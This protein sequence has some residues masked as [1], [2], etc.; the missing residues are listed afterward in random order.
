MKTKLYAKKTLSVFLAVMMLM[1]AWVFV[2]P[3]KAE[4][5]SAATVS[6]NN[7][8]KIAELNG[9][10]FEPTFTT[11]SGNFQGDNASTMANRGYYKNVLYSPH[12]P[13][14]NNNLTNNDAGVYFGNL[15]NTAD[16]ARVWYPETTLIWDG[17]TTPQIP[18]LFDIDSNESNRVGVKNVY[19]SSDANGLVFKDS[20]WT[21]KSECGKD[22]NY[23]T[24]FT[25]DWIMQN[26][27]G[28]YWISTSSGND[29]ESMCSSKGYWD[30]YGTYLQYTG[31]SFGS[32]STYYKAITPTWV[33]RT[34]SNYTG[35]TNKTIY[36]IDYEPLKN[37]L[38]SVQ[39][40]IDS[41]NKEP[42]K[43]TTTS[44]SAFVE[45]AKKLVAANPNNYITSSKNDVYGW[46]SAVSSAL[47]DYNSAKNLAVQ[48]YNVKF[49]KND[50]TDV[51]NR[52]Y[53]YGASIN[54]SSI[55]ADYSNTIK[56]IGETQHQ[57]YKWD[58]AR[59]VSTVTDDIIINEVE[60]KTEA[61]KFGAYTQGETQHSRTCSVCS[62]VQTQNHTKNAGY[63]TKEETCTEDGV[64]T[65]DCATCGKKAIETS[66]INNI[67]G[68]NFSGAAIENV[69]GENGN[70]WKKCSR[71][72]AYGWLSTEDAYENHNWD[73]NGDGQVNASDAVTVAST[74]HSQGSETYTC[75]VCNATW[76]KTL[77]YA[78]HTIT[79]TAKKDVTNQCGGDGNEAFWSCSVCSRVWKD[80]ALT[81]ELTDTTDADSDG[82]PDALE[83]KGPDHEF[84]GPYASVTSGKDGTHHRQCARF[85]QCGTYGP[86][87]KHTWGDPAV[88]DATCEKAGKKVYTCTSGC[89]QTY[90][91]TIDKVAHSMTKHDAV[92]AKCGVAGSIEYYTC[93]IC[94]KNYS[95][96]NGTTV[97]TSTVVPALEHK[98]T[99]H[100]EYDTLKTSATCQAAAVY[101]NHCDYCKTQI[102]GAEH[103]YGE[104]DTV[105][106]HNFNGAIVKNA[107]G[108]HSYKC[109]VAGCTEEGKK[110]TC[111]FT[112]E[113]TDVPSTCHTVGY[114]ITKC[115]T[116]GNEKKENK[117]TF[118]FNNHDGKKEVRFATEAKCN[119]N[120][121][122]G[123]TYCLGCK[124]KIATGS[125]IIADKAVHPHEDMQTYDAKAS[126]CQTAGWKEYKYC[127]ACD[128]YE[129]AKV[130]VPVRDHKFTTYTSNGDGTH[131]AVC[132]TCDPN[133][134]TPATDKQ[135]CKGGTANCQSGAI[136]TVCDTAYGEE[137]E[138][139]HVNTVFVPE[140]PA[141]CQK[142]GTEAYYKC[143]DCGV[144]IGTVEKLE[145][146]PHVYSAWISNGDGTH[147]KTCSLC[148]PAVADRATET[149][150]CSGGTAYCN[151]LAKCADC[152]SEYGVLNPENHSTT[153]NHL[154]D[155]VK[156]TCQA[157]GYTGDYLYDCCNAL[158]QQGEAIAQLEHKFD[159][160]VEGSRVASTCIAKGSVTYKCSSCVESEGVTAATQI[161]ELDID[162]KKH[163]S[164]ETTKVKEV[165]ATCESDGYS[166]DIYYTCCYDSSKT[167]AEN[168]KALKE[169]GTVIKANGQHVY[170]E[171]VPE[172]MVAEISE[173]KDENGKVTDRAIVRK[174]AEPDYN[175][176]KAARHEDGKWY[177]A[178]LCG[179][180]NEVVYSACYTYK[181]TYNCVDTDKCEVCKGLCSLKD[182]N[183]H[184]EL[185]KIE[186]KAATHTEDGTKAYYKC[187]D[188]GKFFLD[189]AGKKEFDPESAEGKA[190]LVISKDTVPCTSWE[191][192]PFE[193]EDP[194]CGEDGYERYRC[195]TKGCTKIKTVVI[196]ATGE[197]HSWSTDYK[198][199]KAPTC[200][201]NGYQAI[202]CM[203][204]QAIKLNSYVTIPATGNHT[205][206]EGVEVPGTSCT[207]PG[208]ITYTCTG[209]GYKKI[210]TSTTGVSAHEWTVE[211]NNGWYVT[212]GNC[213]T[214]VSIERRCKNCDHVEQSTTSGEHD[215][216]EIERVEPTA[217]KDGYVI[218]ECKN[219]KFQ[220]DPEV[221]EYGYNSG[222]DPDE[223][224]VPDVPD[225]PEDPEVSK[226]TFNYENYRVVEKATCTSAEIREYVCLEC[227]EKVRLPYGEMIDHVWLKQPAE[228]ATCEKDGHSEYYRCV[229]CLKEE[230]RENYPAT[231]HND[232]NGDGKCD[233][234]SALLYEGEG[235]ANSCSC[236]CH[237]TGFMGFIYKIARFF[238]KLF[239]TNPSCACGNKHY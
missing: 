70:H 192:E 208:T 62:Y 105:N 153:A 155:Y 169:K 84:T 164:T 187:K 20:Y 32:G 89:G 59:Y 232:G 112:I 102:I 25:F 106:G 28:N 224:D 207:E 2:A 67:S 133:V 119:T 85:T 162:A 78:S 56:Q 110:T 24:H 189:D 234:C 136:C 140:V 17:S 146:L 181:H 148:D 159:I 149:Q 201:S 171:V 131:T 94:G 21:A 71:C 76:I 3:E 74:C 220:A 122:T 238:W 34:G 16:G 182:A 239:K 86:E 219:C 30:I 177:H 31:G 40:V 210:E 199:I 225:V 80:A 39:G 222:S 61:H 13:A 166:G 42:A 160:E 197:S 121:Y 69:T 116:C 157:P 228:K 35:I 125:A 87:E 231:G 29:K 176:K 217:E 180:C 88:T 118:D 175:T 223:P 9:L 123:D 194:K 170:T 98:W 100:H 19:I 214:G 11:V 101:N 38:S 120:G 185:E 154:V 103:S 90:E 129:V 150:D 23:Y 156:E 145:K 135:D 126:T 1:S 221:L 139:N 79:A 213:L 75:K 209:C 51:Y 65:Y 173:T 186:G 196:P 227:G 134:A 50:G 205:F 27:S 5:I 54:C 195:A 151:K 77:D 198:E 161:R 26:K 81:D 48:Q 212:G 43:Y 111:S 91:E 130:T 172:Y 57:I 165:A 14:S 211:E 178:Q 143:A 226:H 144:A 147:T 82:I 167:D 104:K 142:E 235:G 206:G 200:G 97:V 52:N 174:T 138:N 12:F 96:E 64:K 10:N 158:K 55:A 49:V 108:S 45:A 163:A 36:V 188:C 37:A 63:V 179:V 99:A 128:T 33:C 127:S 46:N 73:K 115:E 168:K 8:T 190:L 7:N 233:K 47:S 216:I 202:K 109:T 215:Y 229:R 137:D 113:V 236:M 95:D 124:T 4:A 230:E 60:D 191:A 53:D 15:G 132:D 41:I 93:S 72:D 152:K 141:T 44:V 237:K 117:T 183:K 203:V 218:K 193:K 114:T 6:G 68:H 107:D 58:S 18:I 66:V 204:C 184:D 22:T 92:E 83:T